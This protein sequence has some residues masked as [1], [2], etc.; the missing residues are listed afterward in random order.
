M[1][2][3]DDNAWYLEQMRIEKEKITWKKI[4]SVIE[5]LEKE[6]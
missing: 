2:H 3:K 6:L 1:I 4:L 5:E